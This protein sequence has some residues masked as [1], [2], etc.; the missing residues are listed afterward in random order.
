MSTASA[1]LLEAA[2]IEELVETLRAEG[3]DVLTS[4]GPEPSFDLVA[5]RGQESL[6]FEVKA[7]S[8][9]QS[10][11]PVIHELRRRATEE[12]FTGFRLVVVNPPRTVDVQ[13][14]GLEELLSEELSEELSENLPEDLSR[15]SS[16]TRVEDVSNIEVERVSVSSSGVQVSGWGAVDVELRRG[17]GSEADDLTTS[18]GFPFHFDVVLSP[19]LSRITESRDIRVDV[20]SS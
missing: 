19:D 10:A 5:R 16:G 1:E 6:A 17:T 8:R 13:I 4:T 14:D 7:R 18:S 9:L 2:K 11:L 12:G 3:Y 15:L 20:S